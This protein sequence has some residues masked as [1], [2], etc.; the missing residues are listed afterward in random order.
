MFDQPIFPH[1]RF[2]FFYSS[3]PEDKPVNQFSIDDLTLLRKKAEDSNDFEYAASLIKFEKEFD[4]IKATMDSHI[5]DENWDKCKELKAKM[6]E[7]LTKVSLIE[8]KRKKI[9]PLI[10]LKKKAI[11]DYDFDRVIE[12]DKKI[13]ELN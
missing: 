8:E 3:I 11:S 4:E 12:I 1:P 9:E 13:K 5:A 7:I 10:E 2:F 6:D